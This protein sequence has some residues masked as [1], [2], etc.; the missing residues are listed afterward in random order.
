MQVNFKA[1][2]DHIWLS[3]KI[4]TAIGSSIFHSKDVQQLLSV[5][6]DLFQ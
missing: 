2:K 4:G 1:K 6:G 5:L 3:W